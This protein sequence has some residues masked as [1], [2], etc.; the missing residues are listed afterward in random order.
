MKKSVV[1]QKILGFGIM[2]VVISLILAGMGFGVVEYYK[3]KNESLNKTHLQMDM[4]VFNLQPTLLFDDKAAAD[5][6][7]QSLR[8]DRSINKV[9]LYKADGTEFAAYLP[10][11]RPSDIHLSK[12][13]Y[14]DQK[15]IGHLD[16]EAVYSGIKEKYFAYLLITLL[17]IIFSIP[18]AYLISAPLR[19]QVSEAVVQIEQQSD[20]LRLLADQ[21]VSSEQRERKRIAAL[22]HDHLQQILVASKMQLDLTSKKMNN[23]EYEKATV[24]LKRSEEY[25]NEAIRAAKSLT[26]ELRPPVLYEAGLISAF[27]WLATKFKN[28]HDLNVDLHLQEIPLKLPDNLK[29]L[30]F[31][32][33]KE[34][35]FNVVKYAGVGA[36]DLYSKY[37]EGLIIICVKDAGCGFDVELMDKMSMEKGFGLFSIRERLKLINGKLNIKTGL[38]SGTEVEII[39]PSDMIVETVKN[40]EG[41]KGLTEVEEKTKDQSIKILLVDDHKIVREGIANIL[42]EHPG[43]NVIA[44]AE[45]GM[46]AVEKAGIFMPDIVIMDIN[47]PKLNGIEATRAIKSKYSDIQIIGLSV[48]DENDVAE[49]MKNAGAATLLNKAGDPRQ[50]IEAIITFTRKNHA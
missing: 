8:E 12:E 10:S 42:K 14:F 29:I 38:Q 47:M 36:A 39:I 13:I 48:Q 24:N 22:I 27:Q 7:L 18:A 30:I 16:I 33:V 32:S 23:K 9:K 43:F 17:I 50:L 44:Q 4:L 1:I 20:R 28:D 41:V 6:I 37:E 11:R 46:E 3:I 49:S 31:E 2:S 19:S 45:N 25:L 15:L 40:H 21:V 26:V 34:L 35:L 5:K